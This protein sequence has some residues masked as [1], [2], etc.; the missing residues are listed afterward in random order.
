MVVTGRRKDEGKFKT[1]TLRN[2][3]ITAPYMHDGSVAS[4]QEVI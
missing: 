3:E 2:V 1:P 4:L